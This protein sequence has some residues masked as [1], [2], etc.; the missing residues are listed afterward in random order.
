LGITYVADKS[1]KQ[2]MISIFTSFAST[3]LYQEHNIIV[4]IEETDLWKKNIQAER[5]KNKWE[6]KTATRK[7][8]LTSISFANHL[9][10]LFE[11]I[12]RKFRASNYT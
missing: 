8:L 9:Y 4:I 6:I 3:D 12:L 10:F 1:L 5:G 2:K 7:I 11:S